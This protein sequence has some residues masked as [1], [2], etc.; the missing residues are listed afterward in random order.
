MEFILFYILATL[1]IVFA[2]LVVSRTNPLMSALSLVVCF[3]AT[4]G[5]FA[6][7]GSVFIATLQIIIYAGAIMVLF[8]FAIMFVHTDKASI[9]PR[10]VTFAKVLG[11]GLA[12]YLAAVLA[13][14]LWRP[15]FI[16]APESGET[17]A[18]AITLGRGLLTGYLVPFEVLS[19]LLLVAIV[20]AIML[21]KKRI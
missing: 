3:L 2:I 18:S 8:V 5:I 13:V 1:A 6:L 17:F 19:V 4:A 16:Y 7:L 12:I 20:G 14:S 10:M 11:A 9:K 21:A 15:P